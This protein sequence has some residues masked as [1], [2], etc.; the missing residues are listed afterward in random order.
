VIGDPLLVKSGAKIQTVVHA[1]LL[2]MAS[3]WTSPALTSLA[4]NGTLIY[5]YTPISIDP[6]CNTCGKSRFG[7]GIYFAP[8]SSKADGYSRLNYQG[9]SVTF[10]CLVACG[11]VYKTQ[12]DMPEL[13]SP[14]EG[15]NSVH[16]MIGPRLNYEEICV[17][18]E[19]AIIPIAAVIYRQAFDIITDCSN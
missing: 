14:P 17:Y 11:K 12:N 3:N 2:G 18:D 15:Y 6:D 7:K 5:I 4:G 8:H 10:L 13:T 19:H 9:A 16:G 1:G